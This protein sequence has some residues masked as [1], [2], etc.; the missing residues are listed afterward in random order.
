MRMTQEERD[1]LYRNLRR[2]SLEHVEQFVRDLL[3]D[4]D[5][6]DSQLR[7]YENELKWRREWMD[8]VIQLQADMLLMSPEV[9]TIFKEKSDAKSLDGQ[10]P[11]RDVP[12]VQPPEVP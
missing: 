8:K 6:A 7:R 12:E 1:N 11:D 3:H 9:R 2:S 4:A 5:A 10:K